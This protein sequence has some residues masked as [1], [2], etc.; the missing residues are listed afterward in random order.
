MISD[1]GNRSK[2]II[3]LFI[4]TDIAGEFKCIL[5]LGFSGFFMSRK[6][7]HANTI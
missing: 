5:A 3:A 2:G 1:L 7:S 6:E 4:K